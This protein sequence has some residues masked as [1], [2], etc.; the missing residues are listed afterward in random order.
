MKLV[1]GVGLNDANYNVTVSVNGKQEMCEF[2]RKW[3]N[4]LKRCYSEKYKQGLT[5]YD[6]TKVCDEWL[7]F[8]NFKV[9]M[10]KQDWE[11]K[12]LDKD[13]L[14]TLT[15][16]IYSPDT[17]VFIDHSLNTFISERSIKSKLPYGVCKHGDRYQSGIRINGKRKH[18][19]LFD[20]IGEAHEAWLSERR[21]LVEVFA[22]QQT[23]H[24]VKEALINYE[25][26]N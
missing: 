24:R 2:Y 17:C 7:T 21:R 22:G 19:G 20:S 12:D 5:A 15:N 26:Q 9:W 10:E 25:K 14:S 8:S 11:G 23:D 18:L 16:K 3:T 1:Y 13:L 6:D 4:M